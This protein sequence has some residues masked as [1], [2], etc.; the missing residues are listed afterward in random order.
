MR[1]RSWDRASSR[2]SRRLARRRGLVSSS[3]SWARCRS[4]MMPA[5]DNPAAAS[6]AAA[7]VSVSTWLSG[8]P[9]VRWIPAV[10]A[11]MRPP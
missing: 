8:L 6:R 3:S 2:E 1:S 11:T 7:T 4:R 10:K 9:A 5:T